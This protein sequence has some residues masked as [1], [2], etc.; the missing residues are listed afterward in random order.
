MGLGIYMG[1]SEIRSVCESIYMQKYNMQES[2]FSPR[3]SSA[4]TS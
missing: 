4:R 3:R 2:R 1:Y